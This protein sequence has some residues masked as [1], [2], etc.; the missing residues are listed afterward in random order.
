MSYSKLIALIIASIMITGSTS[1]QAQRIN[2]SMVDGIRIQSPTR[3]QAGKYYQAKLISKKGKI[4]GICWWD[5]E[6]SK[7]FTGP[8]DFKIRNGTATVKIL[9]IQPGAGRMSFY[10]GTSRSKPLIGGYADIYIAP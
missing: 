2:T 1:A 5:W 3:V 6:I 8:S 7:G 9:P 4:S 10:C